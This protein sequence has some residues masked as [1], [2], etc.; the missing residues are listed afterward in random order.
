MW[1]SL[2]PQ[3]GRLLG[4]A[5]AASSPNL[6]AGP[7]QAASGATGASIGFDSSGWTVATHGSTASAS[8]GD[9]WGPT[10]GGL[11]GPIANQGMPNLPAVRP[12]AVPIDSIGGVIPN[13]TAAMLL[14]RQ[15]PTEWAPGSGA[16]TVAGIPVMWLLA[17]GAVLAVLLIKR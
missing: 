7:S 12:Q 13:N 4:S 1:E 15:A 6:T 5:A 14:Q 16:G 17:G 3:A 11:S 9:R 10:S 2:I 8:A